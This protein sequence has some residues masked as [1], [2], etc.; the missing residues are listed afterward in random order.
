MHNPLLDAIDLQVDL[1][2]AMC[3]GNGVVV[4][5]NLEELAVTWA[6]SWAR[7]DAIEGLLFLSQSGEAK[8]NQRSFLLF[9]VQPGK[10]ILNFFPILPVL[11][12]LICFIIFCIC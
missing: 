8:F 5:Q 9:S 12:R 3:I 11:F 7:D 2:V 1:L 4:T 6:S 10:G